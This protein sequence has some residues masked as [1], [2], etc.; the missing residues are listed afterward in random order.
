[1][2]NL[3]KKRIFNKRP[4]YIG[5]LIFVLLGAAAYGLLHKEFWLDRFRSSETFDIDSQ[6]AVNTN[7]LKELRIS[8]SSRLIFS[9]LKKHLSTVQ[10]PVYIIDL[11]GGGEQYYYGYTAGFF[12]ATK[13]KPNIIHL[14]RRL[15]LTGSMKIDVSA[16]QKEEEIVQRHGYHYKSFLIVRRSPPSEQTMHDIVEF[17]EALPKEA[18]LHVHCFAGKGRTT[19]FM[20]M[21]DIIKNH[22]TVP[23]EDIV[24]RQYLLGGIDLF[25]TTVWKNGSYTK[26]ELEARKNFIIRFH[27]YVK[28][29]QGQQEKVT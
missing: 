10:G 9:D 15:L 20:I 28:N 21:V 26:E 25:D 13:G 7:H 18:W 27:Q 23:L 5:L 6:H 29:R 1:L 24:K 4:F 3:E 12:K 16:L 19:M 17:I 22:A 2:Q 11:T 14:L 8:G